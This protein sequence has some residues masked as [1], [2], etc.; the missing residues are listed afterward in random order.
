MNAVVGYTLLGGVILSVSLI[1]IGLAWHWVLYGDWRFTYDLPPTTVGG[2]VIADVE[3]LASRATR[4]RLLV[5]LGIAVLMLTPYVRVAASVISFALER[6]WKYV[7][8][9]AFVLVTLTYRLFA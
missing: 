3:Q 8:F 6:N 2:F 1:A 9:T 5:N 7:A 4:P